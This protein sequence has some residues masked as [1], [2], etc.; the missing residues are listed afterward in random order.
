MVGGV[1]R[2]RSCTSG[3]RRRDWVFPPTSEDQM[4]Q[5]SGLDTSFLR[6]ESRSMYGHVS[7]LTI[8]DPSTTPTGDLTREDMRNVIESRLHLLPPFRWRLAEVPLKLDDPYWIESPEF[9]LD[10][11]IRE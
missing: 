8:Y 10:F 4:R 5:L 2:R 1:A 3:P 6:L 7:G 9:D 11:H